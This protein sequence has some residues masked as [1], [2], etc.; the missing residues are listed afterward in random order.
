MKYVVDSNVASKC[1][2]VETDSDKAI[3]L[4]DGARLG[5]HD[6]LAPDVFP[7]EV[8][9]SLTR[10]ERQGRIT[11]LE[12]HLAITSILADLP[13][14]HSS[15]LL[16]PRAYSISSAMRQGAYDCLYIAL[17]ER[18]GC[19]LVTAD[20]KLIKNMQGRFPFIVA[21]STLP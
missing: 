2:L 15:L 8:A 1:E 11:T 13:T 20:D 19:N 14:L 5:V 9:H 7:V 16:L 18:E 10:A 12:G 17:A 3:R 4:R 21:L 6:L